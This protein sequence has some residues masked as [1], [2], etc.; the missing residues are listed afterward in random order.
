MKHRETYVNKLIIFI[1]F[2]VI[3]LIIIWNEQK[4]SYPIGLLECMEKHIQTT[5]TYYSYLATV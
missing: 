1:E 3:S 5:T 2:Y 4:N